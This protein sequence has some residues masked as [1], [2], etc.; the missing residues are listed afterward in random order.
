MVAERQ[1]AGNPE[2]N[3]IKETILE[4][5]FI[6]GSSFP[7]L[8]WRSGATRHVRQLL[9]LWWNDDFHREED[10]LRHKILARWKLYVT[11]VVSRNN[12]IALSLFSKQPYCEPLSFEALSH[13]TKNRDNKKR[14]T[15]SVRDFSSMYAQSCRPLRDAF[16]HPLRKS[17]RA[18]LPAPT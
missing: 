9:T 11:L 8:L 2:K 18:K 15:L 5:P 4:P 17:K 13:R 1:P 7:P 14:Q 12:M 3:K 16:E 6:S 10:K